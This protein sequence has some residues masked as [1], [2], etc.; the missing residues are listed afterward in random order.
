MSKEVKRGLNADS[1]RYLIGFEVGLLV[2]FGPIQPYG[3][4]IRLLYLILIPTI[5]Y[6]IL[7]YIGK[8]WDAG[9]LENDRLQRSIIGVGGGLLLL[10]CL[11]S[12]SYGNPDGRGNAVIA[13]GLFCMFFWYSAFRKD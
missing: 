12:L 7:K 2:L 13:F 11:N 9:E 5:T 3:I 8:N 4:V 10:Y 1:I 6:F